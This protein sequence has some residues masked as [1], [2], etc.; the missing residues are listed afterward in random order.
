MTVLR[1]SAALLAVGG[2][3]A[4]LW[5]Q[6][7]PTPATLPATSP[8]PLHAHASPV[9]AGAQLPSLAP[10]APP[11]RGS[12]TTDPDAE[13]AARFASERTDPAWAETTRLQ[14]DADLGRFTTKDAGMRSIECRASLCRVELVV[15]SNETGAAF[16]QEW[17]RNRKFAGPISGSQNNGQLVM[18]LGRDGTE[19]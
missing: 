1:W 16:V 19:L 18:Y 7:Q 3:A 17:L 4:W 11:A 13:L 9:T 10:A 5:S 2:A 6:T 8:A 15:A 12:A 14:L